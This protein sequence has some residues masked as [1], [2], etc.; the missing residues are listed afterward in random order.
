MALNLRLSASKN[1][2]PLQ[3]NLLQRP[4]LLRLQLP[5]LPLLRL[6]LPLRP[7]PAPA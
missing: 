7:L 1:P 6:L 3:Q 2:R 4:S 5:R